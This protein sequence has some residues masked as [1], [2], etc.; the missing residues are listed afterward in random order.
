[1]E[2]APLYKRPQV[3]V[4]QELLSSLSREIN[5]LS[6]E[7]FTTRKQALEKLYD[8]CMNIKPRLTLRKLYTGE[9]QEILEHLSKPLL[10][11]FSDDREKCREVAI[12]LY[13][14]L[15]A[16][17]EDVSHF[18]PYIF[19]V[20]VERLGAV[21]LEGI[22]DIPEQMR[23]NPS[24]KPQ[25]LKSPP[26][27]SEEIR[28]LIAELVMVLVCT[29][30]ENFIN[31]ID[32]VTNVL[33][34]LA[35]DPANSNV[36]IEACRA[37]S[38]MCRNAPKLLLHYSEGLARSLFTCLVH[39]HSR[40]RTAGLEA[41]GQVL[42]AGA[43]K[44]N[45]KIMELLIGFRDPNL[46]PIKD[47]Y[48]P[49]TKINYLARFVNDSSP[50][51]REMFYRVISDWIIQ[52]PDKYDHESRLIPYLIAGLFDPLPDIQNLCFEQI[53]EIGQVYETEKEKEIR[54][55]RQMGYQEPWTCDGLMTDLPLPDPFVKRPRLGARLFFRQYV[56][57]YLKG[58]FTELNDWISSSRLHA[59]NLLL[60]LVI[61]TE[62]YIT[63]HLDAMLSAMYRNISLNDS[64]EVVKKLETVL[65]LAGRFVDAESYAPQ[66]ISAIRPAKSSQ[67]WCSV[68][69]CTRS[70]VP[71]S[72]QE[73]ALAVLK[74]LLAGAVEATPPERGLYRISGV[75]TP[76]LNALHDSVPYLNINSGIEMLGIL[77]SII[78]KAHSRMDELENL[79]SISSNCEKFLSLALKAEA[80]S[81]KNNE[82]SELSQQVV[83]SLSEICK[84]EERR[85]S[86]DSSILLASVKVIFED[87]IKLP[88]ENWHSQDENWLLFRC[89]VKKMN[90]VEIELKTATNTNYTVCIMNRIVSSPTA[91]TI[92]KEC[93]SIVKE[94]FPTIKDA[95]HRV[96]IPS[97]ITSYTNS[98][99]KSRIQQS[100]LSVLR[101][102]SFNEVSA[103]LLV[104]L[105]ECIINTNSSIQLEGLGCMTGTFHDLASYLLTDDSLLHQLKF[106]GESLPA[107]I[108]RDLLNLVTDTDNMV[109]ARSLECMYQLLDAL[110]AVIVDSTFL[111]DIKLGRVPSIRYIVNEFEQALV[112]DLKLLIRKL[113]EV[114]LDEE[115]SSIRQKAH[116]CLVLIHK[117]N[118]KAIV[119]EA[120]ESR[121]GG[122]LKR[123][124]YLNA[125]IEVS[126]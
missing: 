97:L 24:Q 30:L 119:M 34:A 64:P 42:Y 14:E 12:K 88:I 54:E 13:K 16:R 82:V 11:R 116:D 36:M 126:S 80:C 92:V 86:N 38:E 65:K 110:P 61:F 47:F 112:G 17:C 91:Y 26:E 52:L 90:R 39:K 1:M 49:S 74:H 28:L 118:A 93:I 72:I 43:Y 41:L 102:S 50:Q 95:Y 2:A 63:Q 33:R 21:D 81:S 101:D 77:A 45:A 15:I 56:M 35:M 99:A 6:D 9:G 75:V 76:I 22:Q 20:L 105:H 109:K 32:E 122:M 18:L 78:V 98:D 107:N 23:P 106:K 71:A 44:Y 5:S 29:G 121:H 100:A 31:I 68:F 3:L 85:Q 104:G 123:W 108:C 124:E 103:E 62:D 67:G 94:L 69:I 59:A 70:T 66:I 125:V 37:I 7:S 117:R 60:A 58:I 96:I 111:N 115:E 79:D 40:V 113:L 89:L 27:N 8:C 120:L 73:P 57:R 10:K 46:V 83:E 87:L 51:V 25:I 114:I 4:T 84:Y 19:T 48:E 55:M 53:E